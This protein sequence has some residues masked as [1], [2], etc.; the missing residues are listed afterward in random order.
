MFPQRGRVGRDPNDWIRLLKKQVRHEYQISKSKQWTHKAGGWN[1]TNCPDSPSSQVV[2]C[3]LFHECQ[4]INETKQEYWMCSHPDQPPQAWQAK[5]ER[6]CSFCKDRP[7]LALILEQ[8]TEVGGA[9]SKFNRYHVL[10]LWWWGS[11]F[12]FKSMVRHL[13]AQHDQLV[14]C[15]FVAEMHNC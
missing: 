2:A 4:S 9:M 1:W 10:I 12:T 11:I 6:D 5:P 15:T 3:C 8:W 7:L 14:N 13:G